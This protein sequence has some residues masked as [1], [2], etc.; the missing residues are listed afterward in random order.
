MELHNE[1]TVRTPVEDAWRILTDLERIAPCMPGARL[2]EV[3]GEDYRGSVKVKVGPITAEYRGVARFLERDEETHRAVLR[4]EG[5]DTR[6]QG[7]ANATITATLA[8]DGPATRVTVE[9][10]LAITGRVA[11]FGRGVLADVSGK[12]LGQFVDCLE[13]TVL[14]VPTPGADALAAGGAGDGPTGDTGEPGTAIGPGT[15]GAASSDADGSARA[16]APERAAA[17]RPRSRSKTTTEASMPAAEAAVPAAEAAAQEAGPAAGEAA[18]SADGV[19][20]GETER[21]VAAPA[22]AAS[23]PGPG[24][25]GG[26]RAIV[27]PETEPVNLLEV[28]GTPVLRRLVPVL[29]G[30]LGAGLVLWLVGRRRGR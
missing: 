18:P 4:A 7:N 6:G 15:A 28:A 29:V 14:A 12:L 8:A 27:A 16:P 10:D 20:A 30:L 24:A 26:P 13:K 25:G 11:Q 23:G 19:G 22:H 17:S 9:T 21:A 3:E 5:R 1:F 2:T